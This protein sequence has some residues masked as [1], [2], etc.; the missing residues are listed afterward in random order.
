MKIKINDI[1]K[2]FSDWVLD[3]TDDPSY[4][5]IELDTP[6]ADIT[7]IPSQ[8]LDQ[9]MGRLLATSKLKSTT[10]A[11]VELSQRARRISEL[12]YF[13]TADELKVLLHLL[14]DWQLDL[15]GNNLAIVMRC[16]LQLEKHYVDNLNYNELI[17][18]YDYLASNLNSFPIRMGYRSEAYLKMQVGKTV[19]DADRE[20]IIM[21]DLT[22]AHY[23][24]SRLDTMRSDWYSS[25]F[26]PKYYMDSVP[27]SR[28]NYPMTPLFDQ[29][30]ITDET[31]VVQV[32]SPVFSSDSSDSL[33]HPSPVTDETSSLSS[34][35]YAEQELQS[36]FKGSKLD[37][38]D[39]M[40]IEQSGISRP[41]SPAPAFF[42]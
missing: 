27:Q 13:L 30:R 41:E 36:I 33:E 28:A 12:K 42:A 40:E 38:E 16:K 32:V 14:T 11:Y 7:N 2:S 24:A 8:T 3:K 5:P 26:E 9:A 10:V 23:A 29:R 39:E 20:T 18:Y 4:T 6:I 15:S 21:H 35:D 31:A 34:D 17:N 22:I 37:N 1:I 25:K 19:E